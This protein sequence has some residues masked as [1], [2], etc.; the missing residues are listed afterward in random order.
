MESRA[1]AVHSPC[2][3][4]T[5]ACMCVC[6]CMFVCA[7][8][9]RED[10]LSVFGSESGPFPLTEAPGIQAEVSSSSLCSLQFYKQLWNFSVVDLSPQE[11]C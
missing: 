7:F 3:Q 9:F 2:P 8:R 10:W 6:A 1:N 11:N 5:R 4:W